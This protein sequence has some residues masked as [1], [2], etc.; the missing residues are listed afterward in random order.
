MSPIWR[1]GRFPL[2]ACPA[3]KANVPL[4]FCLL[5]PF[6]FFFSSPTL[7]YIKNNTYICRVYERPETL[8]TQINGL[9]RDFNKTKENKLN[10]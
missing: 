8:R 10:G 6:R 1:E 9:R 3:A 2:P 5:P 7:S 4:L